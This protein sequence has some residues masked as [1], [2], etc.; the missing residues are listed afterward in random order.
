MNHALERTSPKGGKFIGTCR[1]CGQRN[2]PGSAIF[3]ECPNQRGVTQDEAL[4]EVITGG[5][6]ERK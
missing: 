6:S 2:L 1:L 4:V 3:E 5:V